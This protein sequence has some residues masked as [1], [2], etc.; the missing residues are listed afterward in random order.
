MTQRLRDTETD[1]MRQ[2]L[3]I[4]ILLFLFSVTIQAQNNDRKFIE[5]TRNSY[6]LLRRQG[7]L[8][9]RASIIPNWQIMLKDVSPKYKPAVLRLSNRLRFTLEADTK[10]NINVTHS[11]V[12]P[13]PNKA[14]ADALD[15]LAK[16]VEL[17]V[18]G[19]LM[20][21]APF[22]LS[23]LIPENLEQFVLQDL[24]SQRLLTFKVKE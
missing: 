1:S 20:S 24:E 13:K 9:V 11:I 5:D 16:S 6:S 7:L 2:K 22:M 3:T 12:G 18:T 17:S 23:E 21:W 8:E 19:F 14:T 15:N 10:G 4:L